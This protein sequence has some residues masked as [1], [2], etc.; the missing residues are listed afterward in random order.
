M[1]KLIHAKQNLAAFVATISCKN[2]QC[3]LLQNKKKVGLH[4]SVRIKI[5]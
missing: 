2:M 5:H 1:A 3:C 4:L